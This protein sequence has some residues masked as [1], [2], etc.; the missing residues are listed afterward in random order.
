M[1]LTRR[2]VIRSS[3]CMAFAALFGPGK[4]FANAEDALKAIK[5]FTAGNKVNLGR[6]ELTT[7]KIAENGNIVPVSVSVESPMTANDFVESV[8]LIAKDNPNPQVAIFNFTQM[9][10]E[11]KVSTR[12]RLAQT[13]TVVALAKMSNGE[14]YKTGNYVKVTIGGCGA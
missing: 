2:A 4:V 5:E 13:Q 7:P 10:G 12:M 1:S 3:A 8:V 9:S 11:A 14:I 6:V